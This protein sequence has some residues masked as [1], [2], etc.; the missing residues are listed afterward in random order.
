MTTFLW[1]LLAAAAVLWPGRLA[2]PLDGIPFDQPVEVVA[3]ALLVWAVIADRTMLRRRD[4]RG[5]VV[6]LLAWK[7]LTGIAATQDGFCARFISPQALY[8]D[9]LR[10]PHSWDARADWRAATPQCSA[11]MTR[12]YPELER[13]PAWFF[14]LPPENPGSA[15]AAP[16]RPPNVHVQFQLSGYFRA[17][18]AGELQVTAG[19]DVALTG[20]VGGRPVSAEQLAAGVPLDAGL[21]QVNLDAGLTRSHWSLALSWSGGSFWTSGMATLEP[22]RSIDAWLRPWGNWVSALLWLALLG[23]CA[24]HLIHRIN[25]ATW[26]VAIGASALALLVIGAAAPES[27]L[28]L[29]PLLLLV[30]AVVLPPRRLQ[31]LGGAA[32]LLGLPWLMLWLPR[33]T[34]QAGLFTWYSAGDDWWTFQRFAYRIFLQGYWLQGGEVT[35]WYQPLYRWI[36]GSLHVVFGDS[37][38]GE[39]LWDAGAALAG[40]AFAFHVVRVFAG[41]RWAIAAAIVVLS[42]FTMGPA[43][44]LFGRGLSEFSSAGFLYAGALLTLGARGGHRAAAVLAGVMA[45]LATFTRLNNL[46]MAVALVVFAWPLRLPAGSAWHPSAWLP[47][48]SRPAA[49]GVLGVLAIGLWLFTA[50]TYYY[51]R[52]PSMLHGTTAYLNSV[53]SGPGGVMDAIGRVLASLA[54]I[55]TMNDPPRFDVRALPIMAGV[56]AAIGGLLG[57]GRLRSLPLGVCVFCLAGLAGGFV[58]RGT[59]YPGRFST[60]LA[61]AAIAVAFCALAAI[62]RRFSKGSTS[63]RVPGVP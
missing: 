51:T 33:A 55:V 43:W 44:Y 47:R 20:S 28:R 41:F 24:R 18:T 4:V 58:A 13:F 32:F 40:A 49:A 22:P 2:G 59:A 53:W 6:A 39:L 17:R 45:L 23:L 60:H 11:I 61:P 1:V 35:F 10:V 54:M 63:S 56:L 21:H 15:V 50:R 26:S 48:F 27:V 14:N 62:V 38:V 52:V 31:T 25:S 9:D 42:T 8:L 29:A 5:V 19:E 57:F 3:I 12:D 37:S 7:A 36:A 46:P 30:Y 34:A 16:F